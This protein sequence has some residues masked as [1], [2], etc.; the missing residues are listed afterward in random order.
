MILLISGIPEFKKNTLDSIIEFCYINNINNIHISAWLL[1]P[2]H[3]DNLNKIK[4]YLQKVEWINFKQTVLNSLPAYDLRFQ[5]WENGRAVFLQYYLVL[6]ALE[7]IKQY[8]PGGVVI[9]TRFDL[10]LLSIKSINLKKNFDVLVPPIEGHEYVPF[11][12]LST[13]NDQFIIGRLD[14]LL[15]AYQLITNTKVDLFIAK[16]RLTK[17]L[18]HPKMSDKGIEGLLYQILHSMKVEIKT[19]NI[20]TV[21]EK[22][23]NRRSGVVSVLL[24]ILFKLNFVFPDRPSRLS[25]PYLILFSI[26]K[27][28]IIKSRIFSLLKNKSAL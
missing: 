16:S 2:E 15:K 11:E 27:A 22:Y 14:I 1:K 19:F 6:K 5:S 23:E 12:P 7:S 25:I 26:W 10:R 4:E 13:C 17:S 24:S 28:S 8:T 9:K 20:N 3:I 21:I 18:R